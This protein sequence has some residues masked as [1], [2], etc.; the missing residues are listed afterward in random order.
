MKMALIAGGVLAVV[1]ILAVVHWAWTQHKSADP[2]ANLP[3]AVYQP[4]SSG[5]MLPLPKK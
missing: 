1:V 4:A 5:D 2:L 3:P